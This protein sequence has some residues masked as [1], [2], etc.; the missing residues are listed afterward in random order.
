ME[1]CSEKSTGTTELSG[2]SIEDLAVRFQHG[3]EEAF[4]VLNKRLRARLISFL[5]HR[6]G[7]LEDAEDVAQESFT[8]AWQQR[9]QFD[10]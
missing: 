1:P 5:H 3:N 2:L 4:T 8:R 6:L 9:A 10:H 7:N